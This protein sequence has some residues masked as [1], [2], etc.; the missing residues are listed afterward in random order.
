[1]CFSA[2]ASF[3]GA[4]VI[5][6][7][8][9]LTMKTNNIPKNKLVA[10][11]PLLFA[12]QQLSEGVIWL[13]Y[14]QDIPSWI[15]SATKYIYLL[16]ALIIWPFFIPTAFGYAETQSL[17]RNVLWVFAAVGFCI[18]AIFTYYGLLAPV[19]VE[20]RGHSLSYIGG[21][22][23]LYIPYILT[24]ILPFFISSMQGARW[25]GVLM[26]LA[27]TVAAY[28]Y[29]ETFTSVWCFSAALV[30]IS[31][32]FVIKQQSVETAATSSKT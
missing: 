18:S 5:G 2:E 23:P 24:A 8:G 21:V 4:A 25:V 7:I 11:I 9:V 31:L 30:S 16:F 12:V 29:F 26:A 27:C 17:R 28:F 13:S 1:M 19:G 14:S 22:P 20:V 32:Y 15:L 3:T 6:M 10:L